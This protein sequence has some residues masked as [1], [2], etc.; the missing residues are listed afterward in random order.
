MAFGTA[1][2]ATALQPGQPSKSPLDAAHTAVLMPTHLAPPAPALIEAVLNRVGTLLIVDDGSPPGAARELDR[3]TGASA[4]LLRL[5][6]RRGKGAA[7]NAGLALLRQRRPAAQAVLSIDAD[8]QHPP[9]AIP[10]FLA[11][12]QDA[13][14]VVGD[15]F[16]DLAS[17]PWQRRLANTATSRLLSLTTGVPVRDSQCGMRLLRGRAL[18]QGFEAG[19][20]ESETRQLKRCLKAGIPVAWVP[21]PAIYSGERS[22]FR[23][24]RDSA[25]VL[26]EVMRP[27]RA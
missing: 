5:P 19:G 1:R 21:I 15:R 20:Y 12:A 3:L 17:M 22:S 27:S 26:A 25:L 2:T 9:S 23:P 7:L 4:E 8:G 24:V 11:A 13:E 14:L 16:D 18:D 10:S 6:R